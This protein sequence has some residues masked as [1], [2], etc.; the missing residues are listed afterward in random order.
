MLDLT[1]TEQ[2]MTNDAFYKQ[3]FD[4]FDTEKVGYITVENFVNV[5][6]QNI[7]D[8]NDLENDSASLENVILN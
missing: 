6:K 3:L 5:F 7:V 1:E 8:Q 4:V 2:Q